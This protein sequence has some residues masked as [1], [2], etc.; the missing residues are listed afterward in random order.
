L[1]AV[2]S[3]TR[4]VWL[5]GRTQTNGKDD[6]QTV[7]AIQDQYRLTPLDL[8]GTAYVPPKSTPY[9]YGIDL[10]TPPVDQV[11]NMDAYRFFSRLAA[12]MKD[13]PPAVVDSAVLSRFDAI[14]IAP[15]RTFL[16][17]SFDSVIADAIG[18][19]VEAARKKIAGEAIKPRGKN[20]NGWEIPPETIAKFGTDYTLRAIVALMGLGANLSEDAMYPHTRMDTHGQPLNGRNA[21]V[22]RFQPGQLPPVNAFWSITAY[23]SRQFFIPNPINRYAIGD[24]DKLRFEGDGSLRIYISNASPGA[25]KESNWL[26]VAPDAFNLVM[27]LYWPKTE[28]VKG[29]WKIPGVERAR[30]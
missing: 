10:D 9:V 22:I 21:Y 5:L 27:R 16:F 3:P 20:I 8:W 15:G 13:N 29:T 1:K 11:T 7:N 28:A 30:D 14:G 12:L 23:N 24:R 19:G 18:K 25:E 2:R 26:P 6:V 17:N 4:F